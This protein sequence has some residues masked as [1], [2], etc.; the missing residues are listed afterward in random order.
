[1][2][3]RRLPARPAPIAVR[4]RDVGCCRCRFCPAG[5]GTRPIAPALYSTFMGALRASCSPRFRKAASHVRIPRSAGDRGP[6]SEFSPACREFPAFPGRGSPRSFRLPGRV[7]PG[8][9]TGSVPTVA[10]PEA[11]E[12]AP[13]TGLTGR[14]TLLS[15][16]STSPTAFGERSEA[17]GGLRGLALAGVGVDESVEGVAIYAAPGALQRRRLRLR[18]GVGPFS[19]R[20]PTI[21][22]PAAASRSAGTTRCTRPMRCA[23]AAPK[24]SP[25]NA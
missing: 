23:S 3:A 11:A 22:S 25:V 24:R 6:P 2:A 15:R 20:H 1:M 19:S 5:T 14:E 18:H 17:F 12:G 16:A 7:D 13:G 4:P 21:S 8:Q 10:G 9:A